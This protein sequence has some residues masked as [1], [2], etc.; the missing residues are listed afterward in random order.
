MMTSMASSYLN[1]IAGDIEAVIASAQKS[2]KNYELTTRSIECCLNAMAIGIEM[3]LNEHNV[4]LI[5]VAGL[6]HDVGLTRIPDEIVNSQKKLSELEM[7][8]YKK[9]PIHSLEILQNDPSIP[10]LV[11]VISYQVHE[12]LNGSGYPRGRRGQSIHKFARI[13]QVADEYT[14]LTNPTPARPPIMR[15]HA[16]ESI[17]LKAKNNDLDVN[18]VRNFLNRM[19]LFPIG[20]YVVLNDDSIA[21]VIRSNPESYIKPVVVRIDP[22][23]GNIPNEIS[24][25]NIIN[26]LENEEFSI[27]NV[28]KTPGSNEVSKNEIISQKALGCI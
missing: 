9:H 1:E 20:S 21:R 13:I 11:S 23:S 24:D 17:I 3:G 18:V 16:M 14:E 2:L 22:Q 25:E 19:S 28:V 27:K 4:H 12:R 15:Y 7:L 10:S 6:V 8:E 5:G 26:L